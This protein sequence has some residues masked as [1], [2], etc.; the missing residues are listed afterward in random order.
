MVLL[1]NIL[2]YLIEDKKL[3]FLWLMHIE[4]Q[5]AYLCKKLCEYLIAVHFLCTVCIARASR[6][7]IN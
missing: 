4:Y 2:E 3:S 7:A 1:H 5:F 6:V